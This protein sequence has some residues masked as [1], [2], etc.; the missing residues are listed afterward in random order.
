MQAVINEDTRGDEAC[1]KAEIQRLKDELAAYQSGAHPAAAGQ[2]PHAII[3]PS[4]AQE[5][6]Q[7]GALSTPQAPPPFTPAVSMPLYIIEKVSFSGREPSLFYYSISANVR[8]RFPAG[9]L[10]VPGKPGSVQ[11]GATCAMQTA[12]ADLPS[13]EARQNVNKFGEFM[14]YFED[15]CVQSGH[16]AL[17]G[18][19]RREEAAARC[20]A[21]LARELEAQREVTKQREM[22]AQRTKMIIRLKEDKIARLQV[23]SPSLFVLS[24]LRSV[25][26]CSAFQ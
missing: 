6:M 16:A 11:L 26:F 13:L 24:A 23:P 3:T 4:R 9:L 15:L 25:L 8:A 1:L 22:D 7:A 19:L 17:V 12:G 5:D 18:A 14:S 2:P 10:G 20:V 21:R